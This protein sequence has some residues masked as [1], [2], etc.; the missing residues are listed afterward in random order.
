[1]FDNGFFSDL[2]IGL[3]GWAR[4][5]VFEGSDPRCISGKVSD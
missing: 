2:L 5:R 3:V 1:M 4:A